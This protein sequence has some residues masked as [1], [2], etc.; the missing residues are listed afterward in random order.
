MIVIITSL[1][2]RGDREGEEARVTFSEGE[3]S[4]LKMV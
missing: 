4:L 1:A 3:L 2:Q